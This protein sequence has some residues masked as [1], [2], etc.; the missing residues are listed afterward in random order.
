M[1]KNLSISKKLS[2]FKTLLLQKNISD[3]HIPQLAKTIDEQED[4]FKSFEEYVTDLLIG[5]YDKRLNAQKITF[6]STYL[7]LRSD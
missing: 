2:F 5:E 1:A 4:S 6:Q 3:K 7:T